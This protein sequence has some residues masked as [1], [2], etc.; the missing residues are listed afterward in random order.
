MN[1]KNKS[2]SGFSLFELIIVA[3]ILLLLL[4]MF[5]AAFS[6]AQKRIVDKFRLKQEEAALIVQL[7]VSITGKV[8]RAHCVFTNNLEKVMFVGETLGGPKSVSFIASVPP[9]SAYPVA[10]K[11][12][13]ATDNGLAEVVGQATDYSPTGQ[14]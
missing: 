4:A 2:L 5:I 7:P 9:K 14:H 1:L 3:A 12:Y 8:F 11:F 6:H 13:T 10:G